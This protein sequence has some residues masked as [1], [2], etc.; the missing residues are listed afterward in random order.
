[1]WFVVTI[2]KTLQGISYQSARSTHGFHFLFR[3][4]GEDILILVN[5]LLDVCL[6]GV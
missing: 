6:A 3:M 5:S 1:M 4:G 2:T